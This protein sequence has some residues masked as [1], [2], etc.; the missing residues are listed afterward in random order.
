VLRTGFV[1]HRSVLIPP[2]F[3]YQFAAAQAM[4]KTIELVQKEIA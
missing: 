2:D 3:P 1:T 4:E